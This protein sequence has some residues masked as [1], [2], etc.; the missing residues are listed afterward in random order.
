MKVVSKNPLWDRRHLYFCYIPEF[1]THYG[2]KLPTPSWVESDS[3][4]LAAGDIPSKMRII[5]RDR[6]ISVDDT[7]VIPVTKS[8]EAIKTM[9]VKGS[10]G[11][12]YVVT[13]NGKVKT[14]TCP[15]FSFRKICKH[16]LKSG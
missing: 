9:V 11:E 5:S 2:E 1:D 14:C 15:G 6:I 16:T 12:S 4:C 13:I 8:T 3:I 10:K 7:A